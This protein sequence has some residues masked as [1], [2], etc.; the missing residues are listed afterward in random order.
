MA[1]TVGTNSWVTEAAATTYYASRIGADDYWVSGADKE[2]SL[3]TAYN[4]LNNCGLF[5]FPTTVVQKMKD[6]QCE[7][8]L[9]LLQHAEDIDSRLGIRVQGVQKAGIV[10]EEYVKGAP[11]LPISIFAMYFLNDYL[12]EVAFYAVDLER[13]E[14]E[15]VT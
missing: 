6:A 5:S 10:K 2:A 7:Q 9:F 4:Q 12:T 13:D 11:Q 14:D 15:A 1:I 3:V 8:A